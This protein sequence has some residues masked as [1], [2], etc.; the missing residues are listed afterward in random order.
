MWGSVAI[1]QSR[2]GP[3]SKTVWEILACWSVSGLSPQCWGWTK[4]SSGGSCSSQSATGTG[5]S[6]VL[7]FTSVSTISPILRTPIHSCMRSFTNVSV[8]VCYRS[9][10]PLNSNKVRWKSVV[11]LKLL[12]RERRLNGPANSLDAWGEQTLR[13]KRGSHFRIL[14][15]RRVTRSSFHS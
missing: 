6:R 5:F 4:A 8:F 7:R 12:H 2:K 11:A 1:F 13:K 3:V 14:A 10:A 9:T 15:A